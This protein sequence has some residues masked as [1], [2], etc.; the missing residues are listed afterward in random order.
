LN[1]PERAAVDDC[2]LRKKQ[3]AQQLV[4]V[5]PGFGHWAGK[6]RDFETP[7]GRA[8]IRQLEVLY[9]LRHNL[10]DPG[11]PTAT[12]LAERLQTQRSVITRILKKL[13][14]AGYLTRRPDQRDGRAWEITITDAGRNLSDYVEQEFFKEMEG[15]LGE[16]DEHDLRCLEQSIEI[17]TGVA[18]NL[19]IRG[20]Q[21]RFGASPKP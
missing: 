2:S 16:Q 3:I 12:A 9:M 20:L 6:I 17:L 18:I 4:L 1:Q 8:G 5:L 11:T 15:A 21:I 13:E 19:G 10:L 14:T 7:Y